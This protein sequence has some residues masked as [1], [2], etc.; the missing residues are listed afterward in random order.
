MAVGPALNW[1]GVTGFPMVFSKVPSAVP[2]RACA[3]VRLGKNPTRKGLSS[4]SPERHPPRVKAA[5]SPTAARTAGRIRQPPRGPSGPARAARP[6]GR[7]PGPPRCPP[8]R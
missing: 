5:A 8:P 6:G 7:A 4:D 3:W 1:R 2:T